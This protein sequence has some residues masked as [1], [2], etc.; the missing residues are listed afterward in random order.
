MKILTRKEKKL[1]MLLSDNKVIIIK[2]RQRKLGISVIKK[3]KVI[4]IPKTDPGRRKA[5]K[6]ILIFHPLIKKS[7]KIPK[8]NTQ[9]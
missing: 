8:A 6:I 3:D 5:V 4:N 2:A 9:S 7:K 1:M